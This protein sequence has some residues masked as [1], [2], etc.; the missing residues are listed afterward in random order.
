MR[1]TD[2]KLSF[3]EW[4][5]IKHQ[6]CYGKVTRTQLQRPTFGKIRLRILLFGIQYS[7]LIIIVLCE[8]DSKVGDWTTGRPHPLILSTTALSSM[9]TRVSALTFLERRG[10]HATTRLGFTKLLELIRV[11]PGIWT[12]TCLVFDLLIQSNG[13]NNWG[14]FPGR[15]FSQQE[16]LARA[17]KVDSDKNN[18]QRELLDKS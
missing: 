5:R 1:L 12:N 4:G 14:E 3:Q 6:P 15:K 16:L 18:R 13:F 8:S 7:D 2:W 17:T 10:H 9:M 11:Q